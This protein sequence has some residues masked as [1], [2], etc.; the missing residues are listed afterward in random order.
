MLNRFAASFEIES[1]AIQYEDI[2]AAHTPAERQRRKQRQA[3]IA[4]LSQKTGEFKPHSVYAVKP[5]EPGTVPV[6]LRGNPATPGEIVTPG[7]IQSLSGPSPEFGLAANASDADRRRELAHWITDSNNPL[8]ARVMMNRLWHYHFGRGLVATPNDFGFSGGQPSHP[9]LLEW[10]AIRFKESGWDI[11]QM[12]RLIVSSKTWQQSSFQSQKKAEETDAENRLL[13]RN[14]PRRLEAESLRDTVLATAGQLNRQV[15]G[16]PY[17]DFDTFNFNSQFYE[18]TDPVGAEF[19]R[20]TIYRTWIRSGRNLFLDVFDCP[21]PST[22]APQ[23][24]VTTTPSQ[25]LSL[26]NNSFVLRMSKHLADL[27]TQNSANVESQVQFVA[28][29]AWQRALSADE[30]KTSV[31]FVRQHSLAAYCRVI[32]NSNEFLYV[33]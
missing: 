12:H 3:K 18:M 19:N 7:G 14:N 10:L 32:F 5:R 33:D 26:L 28:Q 29:R 13:W 11:K 1:L 23:R 25:S 30:L 31:D 17:R 8:F 2:L 20:R 16:K 15:G 22:T 24:A 6:L 4:E 27:A 21:D 9:E